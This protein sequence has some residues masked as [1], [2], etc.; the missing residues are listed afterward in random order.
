[1]IE[2]KKC[3]NFVLIDVELF[4]NLMLSNL[5]SIEFITIEHNINTLKAEGSFGRAVI[6]SR[7]INLC[8]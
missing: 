8:Q 6:W 5:E 7:Y 4:A 2:I 3:A 1:M